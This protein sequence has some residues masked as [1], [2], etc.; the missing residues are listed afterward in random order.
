MYAVVNSGG[1]LA[2]VAPDAVITVERLD[3]E[4]GSVV[5]LPTVFATDG[6]RVLATPA[7][8]AGVSVTAEVL[9]HFQG[10]KQSVFK[11]KRRKGYKRTKG[12]RQ[13]LTAV[14]VTEIAIGAPAPRAAKKTADASVGEVEPSA[15]PAAPVGA[16][17]A[18]CEAVKADGTRCANKA[19]DGSRYCGVHAKK[20][21]A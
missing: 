20:Y 21:D 10:E 17:A 12:H 3:A 1:K 18:Q 14:R 5:V 2:K 13:Q 16:D 15:A 11:F 4:V 19:K 8:L 6:E 7:E 9:R